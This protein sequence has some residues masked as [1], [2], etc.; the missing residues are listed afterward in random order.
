MNDVNNLPK[1]NTSGISYVVHLDF[2][3]IV[4]IGIDALEFTLG[5]GELYFP[6]Y[7]WDC[8]S[9]LILNKSIIISQ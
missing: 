6:L 7:G 1:L 3:E 2:E 5:N 9:I 4:R 8:D